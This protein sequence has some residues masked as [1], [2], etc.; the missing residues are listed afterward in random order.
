MCDGGAKNDIFEAQDGG[1]CPY[2]ACDLSLDYCDHGRNPAGLPV[3]SC[4]WFTPLGFARFIHLVSVWGIIRP[5][6]ACKWQKSFGILRSF[7]VFVVVG[8]LAFYGD[9]VF[10]AWKDDWNGVS[11]LFVLFLMYCSI[12]LNSFIVFGGRAVQ[13]CIKYWKY[14]SI[15]IPLRTYLTVMNSCAIWGYIADGRPRSRVPTTK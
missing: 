7:L 15:R 11:V 5:R 3:W 1:P 14:G 12:A 8:M 9:S 4:L 10:C 6:L 13:C 2:A